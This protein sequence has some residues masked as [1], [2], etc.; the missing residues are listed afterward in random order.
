MG[1]ADDGLGRVSAT[2]AVGVSLRQVV[3]AELAGPIAVWDE[4]PGGIGLGWRGIADAQ[5]SEVDAS[6]CSTPFVGYQNANRKILE[7]V[8]C[9]A[10]FSSG[11]SLNGCMP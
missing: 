9:G 4:W 1:S 7:R 6:G 3:D 11:R 8:D 2:F 5:V 10:L